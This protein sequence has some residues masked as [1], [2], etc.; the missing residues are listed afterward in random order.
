MLRTPRALLA[1]PALA[2]LSLAAC[3]DSSGPGRN[4]AGEARFTYTGDYSGTFEAEGRVTATNFADGTFAFAQR[5]TDRG[6]QESLLIYAQKGRANSDKYDALLMAVDDPAKGTITCVTDN[7]DCRIFASFVLGATDAFESD[8]EA[9]FFNGAARLT[10]TDLTDERVKGTFQMSMMGLA[11]ENNA[12]VEVT[13]GS[14][15]LPL[16]DERNGPFSRAQ[17]SRA[18]R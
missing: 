16:L 3:K 9:M 4:L 13:S 14:F 6:G 2:L 18:M 15:D 5:T 10:I 11:V 7:A 17:L 12:E 1:L 8:A